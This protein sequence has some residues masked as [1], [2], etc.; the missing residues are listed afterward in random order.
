MMKKNKAIFVSIVLIFAFFLTSCS[1]AV[2]YS[3][4]KEH[5]EKIK[6][7][8]NMIEGLIEN[9]SEKYLG[10]I[11]PKYIENVTKVVDTLGRQ[12]YNADNFDDFISTFFAQNKETIN[13]NYGE[14]IKVNLSFNSVKEGTKEGMG[15]LLDD[16]SVSYKI[17]TDDISKVYEVS[18]KLQISASNY[19]GSKNSNFQLFEMTNGKYYLH[20]D[21]F[22]YTF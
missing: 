19:S 4:E 11:E 21:S 10:S 6:V 22:L 3:V 13:A 5:E 12:Y 2:S 14:N 8:Y 18:V 16:Y 7:I 17:P 9:D 20:P 1:N 15:L